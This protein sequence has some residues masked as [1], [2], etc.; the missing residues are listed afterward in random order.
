MIN[1]GELRDRTIKLEKYAKLGVDEYWIVLPKE[2]CVEI[3]YLEGDRYELKQ[4]YIL[5]E[6]EKDENYNADKML[7]LRAMPS[8]TIGLKETFDI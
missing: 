7:A 3:Y 5:V 4:S 2:R 1:T 8:V 6:D